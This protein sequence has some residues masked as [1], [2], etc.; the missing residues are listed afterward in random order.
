V[1]EEKD[2][3]KMLYA[4]QPVKDRLS[5]KNSVQGDG[6][7]GLISLVQYHCLRM[8]VSGAAREGVSV[9]ARGRGS[10]RGQE[11]IMNMMMLG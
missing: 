5:K 7:V 2:K 10:S 4:F 9:E 3:S 1:A 8:V 6:A 11:A